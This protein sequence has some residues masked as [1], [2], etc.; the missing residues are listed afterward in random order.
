MLGATCFEGQ[1]DLGSNMV[2]SGGSG[3][4]RGQG[5]G[6]LVGVGQGQTT[7]SIMKATIFS[8]IVIAR[9]KR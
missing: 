5:E 7:H 8:Q 2:W 4:W 1:V 6:E 3:T 9:R